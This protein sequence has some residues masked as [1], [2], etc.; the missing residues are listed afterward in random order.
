[1]STLAA[2][3]ITTTAGLHALAPEWQALW[4]TLPDATPFQSPAWLLPWWSQFGTARPVVGVLRDAGRLV[5]LLPAYVLEEPAGA[6]LLPVGAGISDTLDALI[7]PGA[8][9]D[10]AARLL[11][12]VLDT[13]GLAACDLTDLPPGS[14]L[15]TAPAPPGWQAS[16]HLTD[17]C[18]V[19]RLPDTVA[20]LRDA[21]PAAT[22]RKLRMNRHRAERAG[23]FT[24][25]TADAASLPGLLHA[26]F[27]LHGGRW[28]AQGEPGGVL[29]DPRVRAMLTASATLLLQQNVLRLVILRLGT[30][31]AS[32][33]LG[34]LAGPDRLLLYMS[35]FSAE[36]A[37]CSPGSLLLGAMAEAAVIEGRRELHFL[38][39]GEAYKHAWGGMDRYNAT[40]RFV[41]AR[42]VPARFV[43]I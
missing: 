28:A 7:A 41:P 27:G 11:A 42:F 9:P 13:P 33:C 37:F 1:M 4:R 22:H 6:K 36:H 38:R 17:P 29:A 43:P 14:P 25:Q 40:R 19:L 30:E 32:A 35:G 31:I 26:I 5:G 15:R 21:I 20:G 24:T 2:E 39:G 23:G 3:R 16:L 12:M 8:P 10:A 34:F 18:P